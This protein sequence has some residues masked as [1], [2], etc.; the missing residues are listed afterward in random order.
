MTIRKVEG[1]STKEKGAIMKGGR[2]VRQTSSDSPTK[3]VKKKTITEV[4][5]IQTD[6]IPI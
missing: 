4:Y 5:D 3:A 2:A 6:S 1:A